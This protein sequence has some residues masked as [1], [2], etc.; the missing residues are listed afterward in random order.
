M[1]RRRLACCTWDR[2][3]S[4][5]FDELQCVTRND[6]LTV[7]LINESFENDRTTTTGQG[8]G[9]RLD[10]FDDAPSSC[11]SSKEIIGSTSSKWVL[12]SQVDRNS[13]EWDLAD[14]PCYSFVKNKA[15]YSDKFSHIE[16]I[17]EKF[18][19]LL[20]GEDMTGGSNGLSM[21]LALSNAITNL[22]AT[23]FGELWKLE[24]LSEEKKR[25]WRREMYWL[26]SPTNYMVELV[27]GKQ[28]SRDG[29]ILEIMR[30]R[31]RADICMNLPALQKLDSMLIE[32]LDMMVNTEFWYVEG[33]SR[34]EGRD[35]SKRRSERWWLPSPLVPKTGLSAIGR[36]K[37]MSQARLVYQVLK[38]AKSINENVLAEMPVPVIIKDALPKSGKSSLGEELYKV[39]NSEHGSVE[40]IFKLLDFQS[41]HIVLDCINKLEAAV[42]RWKERIH[43]QEIG[44]SPSRISWSFVKDPIHELEKTEE[45]LD[46]AESLLRFLKDLYPNLPHSF[47]D[48][49]KV[50][51][52]KDVGHAILEGYSRVVANLAFSILS[53][54]QDVLLE[55]AA[56]ASPDS[57]LSTP[58]SLPGASSFLDIMGSP[59]MVNPKV[60]HSLFNQ[61]N[62]SVRKH[63]ISSS[64]M[65]STSD[66]EAPGCDSKTSSAVTTPSRNRA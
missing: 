25:R 64:T 2:E 52:G 65:S 57:L 41:E 6:G 21:A 5:D 53:R 33:G 54:V 34:A 66:S 51:Y 46:R 8:D 35:K 1:M 38:A 58:V 9:C 4:T 24:P 7:G 28:S 60:R 55:D 12:A 11:S 47:L 10:S 3:I 36:K 20:L 59:M 27:P 14:H 50:Q 42:F 16:T 23:I 18:A 19:Q 62:G 39:L 44:K 17:K 29:P 22:A 31:A 61:R 26:I 40:Q 15:I 49:T 32:T 48:A 13:D 63:S 43:E 37:L 45:L 30:P 56:M